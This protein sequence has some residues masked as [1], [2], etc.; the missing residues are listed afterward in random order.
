MAYFLMYIPSN[1]LSIYVMGRFGVKISIVIGTLLFMLGAWLRLF[2]FFSGDS[3]TVF[4]IGTFLAAGGQPFLM[5]LVS[6]ISSIWFGDKERALASAI[7]LCGVPI[8]SFLSFIIPQFIIKES[9]YN[10]LVLAKEHFLMY[11]LIQTMVVTVLCIP[12]LAFMRE[13]PP[14]PPSVVANETNNTYTFCEGL[15]KLA[16]NWNYIKI[17]SIYLFVAGINNSFGSIYANLAA[18]FKY[19]LFVISLGCIFSIS[20]GVFFTF[21]VGFLLDKYQNYKRVQIYITGMAIVA[22]VFHTFSLPNGNPYL[23]LLAMFLSGSSTITICAVTFP[24][25]V[26]ATFPV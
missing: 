9:D 24:F 25:A 13:E 3:F 11:L 6:K 20:G 5:N 16:S 7:G 10:N 23:E 12:A 19:T 26:E 17:F 8:G 15:S 4:Y 18:K 21:L 14:S 22:N 1:F 2:L